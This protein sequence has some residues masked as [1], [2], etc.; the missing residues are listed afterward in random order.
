MRAS[1]SMGIA[2]AAV[3][4]DVQENA[5][6]EHQSG[7]ASMSSGWFC[8]GRRV[9]EQHVPAQMLCR[10][11]AVL[12]DTR[13]VTMELRHEML[14]A[15]S[16]RCRSLCWWTLKDGAWSSADIHDQ[17]DSLIKCNMAWFAVACVPAQP[18]LSR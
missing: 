15:G 5:A 4:Q 7:Y 10:G 3:K 16:I 9:Q 1:M 2:W 17:L 12:C 8:T 11:W 14:Q 6:W 13:A 18:R